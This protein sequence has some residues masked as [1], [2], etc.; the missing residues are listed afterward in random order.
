MK[1]RTILGIGLNETLI[2]SFSSEKDI[3]YFYKMY[4]KFIEEFSFLI[5][6][7]NTDIFEEISDHYVNKKN[8]FES[9]DKNINFLKAITLEYKKIFYKNVCQNF[10]DDKF[11]QLKLALNF[12]KSTSQNVID[13]FDKPER[14]KEKIH[15]LRLI[16]QEL[17]TVRSHKMSG[18]GHYNGINPCTGEKE[19]KIEF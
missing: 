1:P 8:D 10:P 5:F 15:F 6:G 13:K 14:N 18:F 9:I 17:V 19:V 12:F 11:R 7:L 3:L 2:N 4:I 16:V